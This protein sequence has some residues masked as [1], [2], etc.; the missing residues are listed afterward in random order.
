MSKVLFASRTRATYRRIFFCLMFVTQHAAVRAPTSS[1]LGRRRSGRCSGLGLRPLRQQR[2]RNSHCLEQW[3]GHAPWD[4]R[5]LP[6]RSLRR[7]YPARSNGRPVTLFFCRR[8]VLI[9][10]VGYRKMLTALRHSIRYE[11]STRK[12]VVKVLSK[13]S[14]HSRR[15]ARSPLLPPRHPRTE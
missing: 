7:H 15:I 2:R 11:C 6:V 3:A 8:H 1:S 14:E 12:D 5:G 9:N 10:Y 4:Y 13:V